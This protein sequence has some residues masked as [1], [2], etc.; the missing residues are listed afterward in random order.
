MI[1]LSAPILTSSGIT[2]NGSIEVDIAAEDGSAEFCKCTIIH[3]HFL[4]CCLQPP[5]VATS[6]SHL[7]LGLTSQTLRLFKA[8]H[9]KTL[10]YQSSMMTLLNHANPLFVLFKEVLWM[11]SV[12]LNQIESQSEFVMMMVSSCL[13]YNNVTITYYKT[14]CVKALSMNYIIL[15]LLYSFQVK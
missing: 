9:L 10:W 14:Q 11:L 4:N 7:E 6:S 1:R 12:V 13:Y 2:F 15:L 8:S 3:L 5:L